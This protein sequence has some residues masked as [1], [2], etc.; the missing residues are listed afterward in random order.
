MAADGGGELPYKM[1]AGTLPCAEGWLLVSAKMRGA[2]FAPD[3]PRVTETLYDVLHRRPAFTMIALNAPIGNPEQ[4]VLGTRSCDV[5][6]SELMTRDIVASRWHGVR[7]R[8]D[9]GSDDGSDDHADEAAT[10]G[11]RFREVAREMAPYLQRK[12]CEVVPDLSFYQ[13]N[14]ERPLQ[15]A[16]ETPDGYAERR[17]LLVRVPGISRILDAVD[18]GVS[19]LQLLEAAALLWSARRIAARAGKRLPSTPEWDDDGLRIEILR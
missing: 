19:N 8:L 13:L 9:D 7:P 6:A 12:M 3:F 2:T 18:L 16:A 5:E 17:D 10:L 15:F 11:V 1:S 4:A 14:G